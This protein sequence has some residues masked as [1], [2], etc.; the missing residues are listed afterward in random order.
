MLDQS[1]SADNFRVILDFE[2][3]R[4]V[5]LEKTYFPAVEAI[6]KQIKFCNTELRKINKLAPSEKIEV[7][8]EDINKRKEAFREEKEIALSAEL[9]NVSETIVNSNFKVSLKKNDSLGKKT[10]YTVDDTPHNYFALKQAQYNFRS[11]Y[12]VKQANRF[13][14]VSQVKELLDNKFPKFVIKTDIQ[15]FYESVPHDKLIKKLNEENLLSSFTKKIIIQIL[16]EYKVLSGSSKGLPRGIGISAYLAELYMRDLDNSI[17]SLPMV[18]YYAR[19][20]DDIIIII[21]PE[22]TKDSR[23]YLLS[24][25]DV[26][27]NKFHLKRN[28]SKTDCFDLIEGPKGC[29]IEYLG[30]KIHFGNCSV[31]LELTKRKIDKYKKRIDLAFHSYTHLAKVDEKKARKVFIKRISFLT[32]NTKLLNNKSN[33]LVGVYYSHSLLSDSVSLS[34]LDKYYENVINKT[35]TLSTSLRNRLLR[36]SFVQGFQKKIF[37]AFTTNELAE[38]KKAWQR[39]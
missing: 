39:E 3:R 14:I 28:V 21:T 22:S 37:V 8:R 1:F 7:L 13:S 36:Y 27:E 32:G 24:I 35:V 18:S 30:Y 16:K 25:D 12:K 10:I 11:L 38:I 31:K 15:A 6:T 19:Y 2:N 9:Q 23:D 17:R 34:C 4:G 5:Y 20:V 26:I 29:V 33:V